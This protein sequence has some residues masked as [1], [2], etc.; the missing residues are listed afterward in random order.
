[1]KILLTGAG[2]F[3]GSALLPLLV[4]RG[5]T[6]RALYRSRVATSGSDADGLPPGVEILQGDLADEVLCQQASAGIHT[7][8]HLAGQAHVQCS[9][10]THLRNG[11]ETACR[12]AKAAVRAGVQHFVFISSTKANFPSHSAYAALKLATEN[13]LLDLHHRGEL[14][15]TCLRPALVYGP[16]MKGN[17]ATLL[18]WLQRPQLPAFPA[19]TTPLGMIS[20]ADCCRAIVAAVETA[21]ADEA[22]LTGR[23]WEL[24]DGQAYTLQAL[25]RAVRSYQ[26]LPQ[27]LL[28]IPRVCIQWLAWLAGLSAPLTGSALGPGTYRTLYAEPYRR[29][30][31]FNHSTGFWPEQTFYNQLPVLMESM[32]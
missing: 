10:Q 24:H 3:I 28:P 12:L 2:G 18:R 11:Y 9:Q 27:P 26:H 4:Q 29:D 8:I 6:V 17:L 5:H 13:H 30:D 14:Q 31:S 16:G 22:A 21:A 1:M 25:V 7:I 19:S 20:R 15:V 32:A 23:P